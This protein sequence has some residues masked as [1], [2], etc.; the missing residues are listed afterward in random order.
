MAWIKRVGFGLVCLYLGLLAVL[1]VV[2]RDIQYPLDPV[3]LDPKEAG[4]LAAEEI[5]LQLD[6]GTVVIA[7]RAQS[8]KGKPTILYFHGN[9]GSLQHRAHRFV[10]FTNAGY[11][12][13]ALSYPGYGG[14]QGTP[15]EKSIMEAAFLAY[16]QLRIEG[17][18]PDRI[19]IY[20]NS[21]GSGVSVQVASQRLVGG[22]ILEAA[23]F[24][25]VDVVQDN[26]PVFPI[27][28]LLKDQFRSDL[29]AGKIS[30]PTLMIH[31]RQDRTIPH[32][33]GEKLS[34]MIR[35]LTRFV[36][37][38][39]GGHNNLWELGARQEIAT[40]LSERE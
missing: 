13:M 22:L 30:S 31:G 23:Y 33:S 5:T 9:A 27:A 17:I 32:I 21:L 40:F 19:V 24:S 18:Q 36:S 25:I 16:D 20:G 3:R 39:N 26:F 34:R 29:W 11:G 8:R 12:L 15:S 6:D 35:S 14:S 28:L 10:E 37:I 4:V 2:Q 7:W 38:E 1:Y